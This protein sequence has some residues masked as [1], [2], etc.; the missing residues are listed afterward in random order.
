MSADKC[1]FC[2]KKDPQFS[3]RWSFH[4]CSKCY[5]EW[6]SDSVSNEL[7]LVDFGTIPTSF[8]SANEWGTDDG[9]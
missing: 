4:S 3:T 2:G 9:D 5:D 1:Y 8:K 6:I 7:D